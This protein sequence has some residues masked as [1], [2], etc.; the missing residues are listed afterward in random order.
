MGAALPWQ[1]EIAA[2]LS[3]IG[4]VTVPSCVLEKAYQGQPLTADESRMLADHPRTGS[5]LVANIPRLED[6]ATIIRLQ[7]RG[8]DGTGDPPAGP[9]AYDIP[10]GARVLKVALD[11]DALRA[12]GLSPVQ[13]MVELHLRRGPYDPAV[14]GALEAVIGFEE[15]S[16]IREI[17]LK[18]L[19]TG[20]ILAEDLLSTDG[21]LLV[22]KGQEVST[23]LRERLR[24]FAQNG[25]ITGSL[26]VLCTTRQQRAPAQPVGA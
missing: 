10:L 25:R 20:M 14:L 2:L 16:E 1:A 5:D 8:F 11:Y 22:T 21:T 13:A 18:E 12:R 7:H 4:C 9:A 26:R 23:S 15:T 3:Q 19:N 6:V 17:S 24:N